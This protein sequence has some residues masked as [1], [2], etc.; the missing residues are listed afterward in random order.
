MDYTGI[1]EQTQR[2]QQRRQH[3][4]KLSPCQFAGVFFQIVHKADAVHVFIDHIGG[5]VLSEQ[6][7]HSAD[8]HLSPQMCQRFVQFRELCHQRLVLC[9]TCRNDTD[10]R[11]A[12]HTVAQVAGHVL[13][14]EYLA[15]N[16][17]VICQ[18]GDSL[19]V[20]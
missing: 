5:V 20:C 11:R 1:V 16:G 7:H 15:A 10:D 8:A 9:Q 2:C 19:A 17:L 6:I 18:I 14:Q 4:G 13:P 12:D 3:V